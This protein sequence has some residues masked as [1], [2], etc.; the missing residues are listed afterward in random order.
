[1][2]NYIYFVRRFLIVFIIFMALGCDAET[3]NINLEPIIKI[4]TLQN[5]LGSYRHIQFADKDT[6]LDVV[7]LNDGYRAKIYQ[8]KATNL[9]DAQSIL[10]P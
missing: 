5:K 9:F 2:K 7:I 8:Q 4:N 1:M 10:N 6:E 3:L